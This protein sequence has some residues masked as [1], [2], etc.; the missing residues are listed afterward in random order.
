MYRVKIKKV[1]EGASGGFPLQASYKVTNMG[2]PGEFWPANRSAQHLATQTQSL[3]LSAAYFHLC[4]CGWWVV[5]G[6]SFYKL[7]ST[8]IVLDR[9]LLHRCCSAV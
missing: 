6:G 5:G 4:V 1:G 7:L 2:G 3:R 8:A 9:T